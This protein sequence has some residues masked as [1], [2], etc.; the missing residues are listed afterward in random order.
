[1]GFIKVAE[2]KGETNAST[3]KQAQQFFLGANGL[4]IHFKHIPY[5]KAW[6]NNNPVEPAMQLIGSGD[7]FVVFMVK[8][9]DSSP[10][11]HFLVSNSGIR[12]SCWAEEII[13]IF[14]LCR[15]PKIFLHV[16]ALT[17]KS[18]AMDVSA[19]QKYHNKS[20]TFLN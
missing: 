1:M 6:R 10:T 9:I 12:R 11:K 7:L 16:P 20:T 18:R 2:S 15:D 19:K 13:L 14:L 5:I 8:Q 3:R 17:L 4:N